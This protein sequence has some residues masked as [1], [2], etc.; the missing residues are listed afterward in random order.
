MNLKNKF[1][2]AIILAI[3]L[4]LLTLF[5]CTEVNAVSKDI[6]TNDYYI[7][8]EKYYYEYTGK[9]IKP[10]VHLRINGSNAELQK[11]KDFT[12]TYKNN[13]DIGIGIIQVKGKGE[14]TGTRTYNFNI[15]KYDIANATVDA[16][17]DQQYTGKLIRPKVKNVKYKGKLLKEGTDYTVSYTIYSNNITPLGT[18]YVWIYGRGE[19]SGYKSTTFKVI[20]PKTQ[21]V[22][23]TQKSNGIKISWKKSTA[24]VEGY[25]VYRST[26]KDKGYKFIATVLGSNKTNYVDTDAVSGK[27]YYYKVHSYKY[28]NYEKVTGKNSSPKGMIYSKAVSFSLTS[29]NSNATLKWNK[30]KGV[31]GY[32]IYRAT[33]KKGKYKYIKTVSSK[34]NSYTDKVKKYSTYY[35]KM[36]TYVST[37][38]GKVH[39]EYSSIKQKMP[40][41]KVTLRKVKYSNKKNTITW[42]RVSDVKGY[43]IYRSTSEKGTYKKIATVSKN[44]KSYTDK[45]LSL[46][47]TYYYKVKAYAKKG[48][49]DLQGQYSNIK[50]TA[51]GTKKQRMNKVKLQP[52]KDFK[53]SGFSSYYKQYE[54]LIKK[55]T[56]SKMSTYEKVE[57]MYKYLVNHLYHKDGYHCKNFA[58]TF[59]GICR[60]MGL[61]AYCA[62]GETKSGSGYT[63]HTWTIINING[64]EYIF[65]ASLERHNS[66]R[67]SNKK[68]VDYRYFFKKYSELP[69][70]YKF[71]GYENWWP[72]FMVPLK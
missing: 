56:N 30:V 41:G 60:V 71:Y 51:T 27:K 18:Q 65:D 64:E 34:K 40:V 21:N 35:Y 7:S 46:G 20:L 38:S 63:A 1:K 44:K 11:D 36:R 26:S 2:Y 42:D 8:M 52:D 5:N 48:K 6:S 31:S 10:E 3:G 4:I 23:L 53:N 24:D 16:I 29:G 43:R 25:E 57:K 47:K 32:K 61:D 54:K 59:A 22:K 62:E 12:V 58:G 45:S 68:Q 14:Y 66:D 28:N 39:S 67:K 55:Q 70:V 13:R 9:Q 17:P 50:S 33:S 72:Y 37:S 69:K 19:Y 15:C 49:T